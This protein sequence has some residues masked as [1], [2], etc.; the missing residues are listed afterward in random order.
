[1]YDQETQNYIRGGIQR[2]VVTSSNDKGGSQTY[3]L[4]VLRNHRRS[5]VEVLQFWGVSTRPPSGSVSL[6]FA[7]GGDHGD[8]VAIPAAHPS[9]RLGNLKEGEV[10]L[11]TTDGSRVHVKADGKID[12]VSTKEVSVSVKDKSTVVV[13]EDTVTAKVEDISTVELTKDMVRATHAGTP[14][15][16]KAGRIDLGADPAP[17]R[18]MTDAG[19]SSVVYAAI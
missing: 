10:A 13:T 17:N 8:V 5:G 11:Y 7:V 9:Q 19:P 4:T 15:V 3:D 18:V 12:V 1:M 16:I 2:G 6:L 14:V